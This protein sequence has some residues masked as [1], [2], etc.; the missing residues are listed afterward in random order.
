MKGLRVAW[1]EGGCR[2]IKGGALPNL[3]GLCGMLVGL[4]FMRWEP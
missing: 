3:A 1:K 4:T 2:L